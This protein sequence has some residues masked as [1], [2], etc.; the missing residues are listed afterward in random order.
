MS[1]FVTKVICNKSNQKWSKKPKVDF[2]VNYYTGTFGDRSQITFTK[3]G[4]GGLSI[5]NF[6]RY[7]SRM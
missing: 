4:G 2:R 1:T 5:V 6:T 7:I 3:K